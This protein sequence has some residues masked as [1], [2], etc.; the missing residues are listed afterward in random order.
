MLNLSVIL[1]DSAKRY[2]KK[3]A[4]IFMD[5]VLS[6]VQLNEAANRIANGLKSKGIQPGDKVVLSCPNLPHFPIIYYGIIKAGA[7]V[8]PLSVL[9]KKDEIEY[10]L[11][12][13]DA[14]AYCCFSGTADL[15]M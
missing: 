4:F 9:L 5:T 15:P 12:D 1:D 6:Y 11:A 7:V 3:A 2:P 8:V 10:H 13:S 14:K